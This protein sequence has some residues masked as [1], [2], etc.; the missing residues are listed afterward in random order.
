[1]NKN[2]QKKLWIG[3]V[4]LIVLTPLGLLAS[5]TAYGEWGSDELQQT[6]GYVPSG[7]EQG[8]NLWHA[9]FPDYT[10]AGLENSFLQSSI[11]YILSAVIGIALIYIVVLTI[12]KLIARKE[13]QIDENP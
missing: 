10:V 1:M 8:E 6:L 4:I 11:G 5:G 12:G 2:T 13:D 7:I 3:L 9:L